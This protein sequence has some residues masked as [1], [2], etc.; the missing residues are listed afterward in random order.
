MIGSCALIQI[1]DTRAQW[2]SERG[3]LEKASTQVSKDV[4]SS[5]FWRIAGDKYSELIRVPAKNNLYDWTLFANYAATNKMATNSVFLA[6]FDEN[7]LLNLNQSLDAEILGGQYR[8]SSLYIVE[9]GGVIPV[10]MSLDQSKHLFARIDGYNVL[11]PGWK[12][13]SKCLPDARFDEY[14]G[15]IDALK[16]MK[17]FQ[18]SDQEKDRITLT[19]LSKGWGNPEPWGVWSGSKRAQMIIPISPNKNETLTLEL[20]ALIAKNL[21]SQELNISIDG[22]I[23]DR[24]VLSQGAGNKINLKIPKF[25]LKKGFL[26]LDFS[27]PD[28]ARPADLGI[29]A[30]DERLLSI[31]LVS[32]TWN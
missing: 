30:D 11:A 18:F 22:K 24:Y 13:C 19:L 27:L 29:T 14:S 5:P 1:V 9:D 15:L 16:G 3:V 6:R 32:A 23:F 31:G 2:S 21:P 7:K 10:L 20:R 25:L 4:L 8:S 12:V 17:V 28:A 26:V